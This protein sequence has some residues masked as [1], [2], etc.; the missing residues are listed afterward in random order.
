[1]RS[2]KINLILP[3]TERKSGLGG[4]SSRQ[5]VK[6][7]RRSPVHRPGHDPCQNCRIVNVDRRRR[8]WLVGLCIFF[9]FHFF[10]VGLFVSI[11]FSVLSVSLS[12]GLT[13]LYVSPPPLFFHLFD[14]LWYLSLLHQFDWLVGVFFCLIDWLVR[15]SS[16]RINGF[17]NIDADDDINHINKDNLQSESVGL[18]QT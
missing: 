3:D 12:T 9:F 17:Y 11:F 4:D 2:A 6:N 8:S 14:S 13:G 18:K 15:L 5:D 1:M 7:R 16:F 10:F